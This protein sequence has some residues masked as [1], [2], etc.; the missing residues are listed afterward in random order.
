MSIGTII[1]VIGGL[2]LLK[3]AV[4]H[5]HRHHAWGG[6]A[7]RGGCGGGP[8]WARHGHHR[9]GPGHHQRGRGPGAWMWSALGHLDLSPAQEK[10]VRTEARALADKAR[11]LKDEGARSRADMA[12]AVAGEEFEEGALASMFIRH[13]DVMREL[14]EDLAG[15]LGRIHTV[16]DP[17]QRQRLAELLERGRRGPL[18]GGPYRV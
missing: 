14:R 4:H 1:G 2:V 7:G 10:L 9:H 13:D 8:R 6:C 12:R 5:H 3:A 11:G 18:G 16:L 17:A 15:A